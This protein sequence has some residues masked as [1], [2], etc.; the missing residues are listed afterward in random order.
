M[1]VSRVRIPRKIKHDVLYESAYVCVLCQ[2]SGCQIHHI[3][4]DHSNNKITNLVA[5]CLTHHGEAHTK[6]EMGQNLT[7]DSLKSAKQKWLTTVENNRLLNC[8]SSSQNH[9]PNKI[10]SVSWGYI[11]HYRALQM[12]QPNLF[13]NE[14]KDIFNY[15][16]SKKLLDV[17]AIL[18]KPNNII[19]TWMSIYDWYDYG[20]DHRL[21]KVFSNLVDQITTQYPITHIEPD[22]WNKTSMNSINEGSLL[23]VNKGFYFKTVKETI[24]NEHRICRTFK[25]KIE[26]EFFVDTQDM[27]GATS[28]NTSFSGHTTCAA[29]LLLKSKK[30]EGTKLILQCT[31]IALGVGFQTLTLK[32]SD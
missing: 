17:S 24:N 25:K 14:E 4:Q 12:G 5:L 2:T 8:S 29:L 10:H 30:K 1:K 18:I 15:C 21:H 28:R 20:D 27:L 3:D 31:P 32:K 11:N 26:I 9:L 19:D 22:G 7:P 6:R 23:F 16:L 13:N